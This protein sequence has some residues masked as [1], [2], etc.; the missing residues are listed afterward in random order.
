MS[1][2]N[3]ITRTGKGV[4]GQNRMKT[5]LS[6]ISGHYF[7]SYLQLNQIYIKI[8]WEYRSAIANIRPFHILQNI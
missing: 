2:V 4:G 6:E 7:V 5:W 3:K 8:S 1:D